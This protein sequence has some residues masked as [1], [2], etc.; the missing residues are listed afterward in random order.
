MSMQDQAA[1]HEKER[2]TDLL[3][4]ASQLQN[5]AYLGSSGKKMVAQQRVASE[6]AI[7]KYY[8]YKY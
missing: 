7:Q 2:R 6:M 5:A 8:N 1:L 3:C 4:K